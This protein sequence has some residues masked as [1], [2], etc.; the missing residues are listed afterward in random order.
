MVRVIVEQP[1]SPR[2]GHDVQVIEVVTVGRTHR[3]VAFGHHD[4]VVVRHG[5]G[6]IQAAVVVIDALE[7]ESLR[8]ID[9]VVI[10]LFELCFLRTSIVIVFVRRITRP[11]ATRRQYLTDQQALGV[12]IS[13]QDVANVPAVGV[14]APG[15]ELAVLGPDQAGGIFAFRRRPANRKFDVG[16]GN[17]AESL[18][19]RQVRCMGCLLVEYR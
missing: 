4:H 2:A 19:G 14:A 17:D 16:V 6:F 7:G 9:A 3:V 11:V 10:D 1:L 8:W 13:E 5:H 18:V 12:R 15:F